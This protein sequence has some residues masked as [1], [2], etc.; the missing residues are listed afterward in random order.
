MTIC[1]LVDGVNVTTDDRHMWLI[2]FTPGRSHVLR[3]QLP[4]PTILM[5]LRVWNYNK[6]P[7]DTLRGA[8]TPLRV[9]RPRVLASDCCLTVEVRCVGCYI[10]HRLGKSAC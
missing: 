6:S 5:G 4:A 1:R 10:N 9:L 7:E 2:P 3:I 8:R